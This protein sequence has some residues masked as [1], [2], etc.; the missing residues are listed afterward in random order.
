MYAAGSS[1]AH[2]AAT[3]VSTY[4]LANHSSFNKATIKTSENTVKKPFFFTYIKW[5][6]HIYI[7]THIHYFPSTRISIKNSNTEK[8]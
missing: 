1:T 8:P 3:S 7:Y 4:G 6:M 5:K 2:E